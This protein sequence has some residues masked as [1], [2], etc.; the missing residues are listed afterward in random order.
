MKINNNIFEMEG[1]VI[2]TMP[3]ATF[4]VKLENG[5]IIN[6]F[7]SGKIRKN[8]IKIMIGDKVKVIISDYDLTKGR[9]VHRF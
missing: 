4:K 8:F 6:S 2:N 9:I 5:F 3:N 7:V 1:I